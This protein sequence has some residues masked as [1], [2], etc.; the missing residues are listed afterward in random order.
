[1][2]KRT[3]LAFVLSFVILIGFQYWQAATAPPPKKPPVPP[4]AAAGTTEG[5]M[6]SGATVT[7]RPEAER[8]P[9]AAT[10]SAR[11]AEEPSARFEA[12]SRELV[13]ENDVV[14]ARFTSFGAML[15]SYTLKG[16]REEDEPKA[17]DL[18][19]P[20]GEPA[21]GLVLEVADEAVHRTPWLVEERPGELV[22]RYPLE[23]SAA[24]EKIVRLPEGR[25]S[26]DV[27]LRLVEPRAAGISGYTLFATTRGI[28]PEDEN[29]K[30][31]P[32]EAPPSGSIFGVAGIAK[33]DGAKLESEM[34]AK[35]PETGSSEPYEKHGI[36]KFGGAASKYFAAVL[37]P[38]DGVPA[39]ILFLERV[40][41]EIGHGRE[42][43]ANVRSGY[44]VNLPKAKP[45]GGVVEHRFTFFAGPK[46]DA[47]LA[48]YPE[49]K[50]SVLLDFTS[51]VPGSETLSGL[52]LWFLRKLEALVRSYGIAI[53][54]LTFFVRVVLH[55]LSRASMR[56]MYK[57]QKLAPKV[58]DIQEKY[59][60]KKS[61]EAA[62]KMNVEVM[63][64]YKSHGTSP[65]LGCLPTFFQLPVFIGLYNSLAYSIELRQ[66]EFLYIADLSRPDRLFPFGG[67]NVPFLGGYFNLLPIL[68][69]VTM[70]VQQRMQPVPPDPQQQQQ[71][72]MMQ[73]MM[74]LFG[75]L[76]YHVPS[77]LV[78]YFLTSSL[79]G[80]VEQRWVKAQIERDEGKAR[81]APA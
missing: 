59:K 48:G 77:G 15:V 17:L 72:K 4:P 9:D 36:T 78:L 5:Q 47:V 67:A 62:Q 80:M 55:P 11:P 68:M 6:P 33:D 16:F 18:L 54:V 45:A 28:R 46:I 65:L 44:R 56:N 22:F 19:A 21:P 73:Y 3:I 8:E 63:E 51:W 52:F 31:A 23:G 79:L 60:G 20:A 64:L 61:K 1:V 49:H 32:K 38:Q 13:L 75:V 2:E 69:V 26:L 57:M 70:V 50:L 34:A 43:E 81:M 39:P 29:N 66:T 25:Y 42:P 10:P 37:A 40:K 53:I 7:A 12:P 58:K 74:V 14:R 35:L 27:T 76:F 24:I 71:A 30:Y 41:L